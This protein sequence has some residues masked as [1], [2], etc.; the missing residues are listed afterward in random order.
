MV[1]TSSRSAHEGARVSSARWW[2]DACSCRW[3][4][5]WD[6]GSHAGT[7]GIVLDRET[8][9][10]AVADELFVVDLR[11]SAE[12]LGGRHARSGEVVVSDPLRASSHGVVIGYVRQSLLQRVGEAGGF[13]FGYVVAGLNRGSL[14]A[15][16][17]GQLPDAIPRPVVEPV[18]PGLAGGHV[19]FVRY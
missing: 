8:A 9:G 7:R 16:C 12:P 15:V 5:T 6:G 18:A 11:R 10:A 14:P 3:T 17:P 2:I 1:G 19:G 13:L 4:E